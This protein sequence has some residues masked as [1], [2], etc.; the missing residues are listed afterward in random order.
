[1]PPRRTRAPTE[2]RPKAPGASLLPKYHRKSRS[3]T[4][5]SAAPAIALSRVNRTVAGIMREPRRVAR[6]EV[7]DPRL[8]GQQFL[9]Q[10]IGHRSLLNL[11]PVSYTHLR[12]HETV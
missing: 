5:W 3:A 6:H 8:A 2:T 10:V 4:N 9:D 1:M 11:V 7:R 12:A